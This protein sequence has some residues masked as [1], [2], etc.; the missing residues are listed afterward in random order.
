M[1]NLSSN[2][3]QFVEK[4][5]GINMLEIKLGRLAAERGSSDR[6]RTLG[7]KMV[8]DHQKTG[9]QL[10][11][12]A[13]RENLTL[14]QTLSPEMQAEYDRMQSMRGAE[15]DKAYLDGVANDHSKA[16]SLYQKEI[17]SGMDPALKS[18]ATQTLPSLKH[19]QNMAMRSS[20]HM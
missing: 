10:M 15:F 5:A 4:A 9:E 19:H 7:Q 18:F 2:D 13:E 6:V 16:I 20:Q 12:I 3:R 1:G 17:D 8:D 14:P 11:K